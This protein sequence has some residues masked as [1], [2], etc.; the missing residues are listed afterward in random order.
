MMGLQINGHRGLPRPPGARE[1]AWDGLSLQPPGGTS[2]A[3]LDFRPP[4]L[5]QKSFSCF[6]SPSLWSFVT[7]VP[8]HYYNLLALGIHVA[9]SWV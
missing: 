8:R 9:C 7:G 6:K 2:L 3:D 5:G 4:E 1:E